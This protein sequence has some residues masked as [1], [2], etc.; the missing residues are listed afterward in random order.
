M[1]FAYTYTKEQEE[2]RQEVRTWLEKNIPENM[3]APVDRLDLSE[4]HYTFWRGMHKILAEKGWFYPTYP[5]EY[6]G[7]GLSGEHETILTEEFERAK[8]VGDFTMPY[9]YPTL[10]VWATEEQKQRFL[11][12]LLKSEKVAFQNFT[13]PNAGS[14]LASLQSRAVRDGDDWLITGQKT[15]IS[16]HG[17]VD[18]LF[19]PIVTDPDA[20]RHRNLGYFMIPCPSPGLELKRLNLL[21]GHDQSFIF[22]DNVRVP[23]DHL[24]GGETEGWQVA[25]TTLEIEHGGRGAAFPRDEAMDNLLD[26]VRDTKHNG[27]SLGQDPLVQQDAMAAYI[28]SH[29]HTLLSW[30]NYWM[31]Q[32]REE[33]SYHGSQQTLYRKVYRM[34]NADRARNIMGMY[35][36]LGVGEPRAASEGAP[37]V[38]QRSSLTGAHPG[39]TIEIQKVIIAR[40][41]GISRTRERAAA[42][43]ATAGVSGV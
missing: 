11:K 6:G 34:T 27:E 42:T 36:M 2:F 5:K 43:P 7:G 13:E 12:P 41:L 16:G 19:G 21:T 20:S 23:G 15:F 18:Y 32:A 28:D 17:D 29:V 37:E 35:S 40:R 38:Y 22:M 14:D 33:M 24:I 39:G 9:V 10:L 26:Y 4:E 30:R 8:V 1:D 25:Q 3:K 31:Y